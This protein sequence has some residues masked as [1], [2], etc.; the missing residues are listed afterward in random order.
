MVVGM[1]VA[2][3]TA[4][5]LVARAAEW[6]GAMVGVTLVARMAAMAL[7][8]AGRPA[9]VAPKVVPVVDLVQAAI[10]AER[11]GLLWASWA[12]AAAMVSVDGHTREGRIPSSSAQRTRSRSRSTDCTIVRMAGSTMSRV[13]GLAAALVVA[14]WVVAVVAV[15]RKVV[16]SGVAGSGAVG[17]GV[18]GAT[19]GENTAAVAAAGE[20]EAG[21]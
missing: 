6:V 5:G 11:L 12:D 14:L 4:R 21:S 8:M 7:G 18:V 17:S 20:A 10:L 2:V 13:S 3:V 15:A 16:G 9:A 1:A 19:D